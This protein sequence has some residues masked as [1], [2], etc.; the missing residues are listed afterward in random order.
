MQFIDL[1]EQ[2]KLVE[3]QI[4]EGIQTVLAHGQ[5]IM[6]PEVL[7]LEKKLANYVNVKHAITCANGTDALH[8]PLLA[9]GIGK[10]DAV[11]T[12]TFS[13][14][15]TAE[16]ISLTGATPVFVD[17][18]EETFN[19]CPKALE[20]EIGKVKS[21][22]KL[23][24][25]AI[26]P[27]DLFGSLADYDK[28]SDI[29]KKYEVKVLSDAAQSFGGTH[30]GKK[31]GSFGDAA[32]TSFFP[33]KPLGCYGDGGAM[34]TDDD[35]LAEHLRSLRNHGQGS[36]KYD[37]IRIGLN[38]RLDTI[39]AAILLPKL[40]ILSDEIEKRNIVAKKYNSFLGAIVKT[41]YISSNATSAWAQYSVLAKNAEEREKFQEI[42]KEA[43]IP[44][45]I[46]YPKPLHLQKAFSNL[47]YRIGDFPV[48]EDVTSRIFSL[49]MHPYLTEVQ[50]KKINK[51]IQEQVT[52]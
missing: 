49:P 17:I 4:N 23:T 33:A 6:G 45:M 1:Q 14:F 41:P 39:Q 38:S 5:F 21:E 35:G 36:D 52:I 18:E 10:G 2:Y 29:A 26:I 32:A 28:I 46:Y 40:E 42:L 20:K 31:A 22:G 24:A 43:E 13:F 7:E 30:N 11:F 37:N 27:V 25:K 8:L 3:K 12:T 9:W 47:G 51:K 16:V 48:A 19:I 34:F 44:T 15:A 50:I